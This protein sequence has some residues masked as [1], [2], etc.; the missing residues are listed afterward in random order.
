MKALAI[1]AIAASAHAG[2]ARVGP[3]VYHPAFPASPAERAIDVPAFWLD[4][5]PVTNADYLAFVRAVPEW[6]RDRAKPLFVDADYLSPWAS[7]DALGGL[8]PRAPVV[9]VSWFA[10]RAYCAWR[11]GRL[12]REA[13]WELAAD[14]PELQAQILA[15]YAR[16]TPPV[17]PDVGGA[18][19]KWGVR[20]LHGLVW[21]WIDDFS[22]TLVGDSVCGAEANAARDPSAYAAFMR[23]AFRG[24]LEARDSVA[25]L[26]FRC[27]YDQE[28]SR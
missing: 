14:A 19:N 3:G 28:P 27:A 23:F 15:W 18:P 9:R 26:G 12:P 1:L 6:R 25:S 22:A 11:G 2:P 10:A 20:D 21:E 16:P 7:A 17:L 8:S 4:R 24:S 5:E 13:E